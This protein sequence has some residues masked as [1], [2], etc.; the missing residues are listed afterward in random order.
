[1]L[2]RLKRLWGDR[3][4]HH[5]SRCSLER[6]FLIGDIALLGTAPG[7]ASLYGLA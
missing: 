1:M 4:V 6:Y 5:W 3:F 2:G 7:S